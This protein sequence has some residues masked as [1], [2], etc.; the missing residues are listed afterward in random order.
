MSSCEK[1]VEKLNSLLIGLVGKNRNCVKSM[2]DRLQ[3]VPISQ[4]LIF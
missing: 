2:G 4:Q 1:T 3:L